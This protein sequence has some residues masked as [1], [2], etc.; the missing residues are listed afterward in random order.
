MRRRSTAVDATSRW[1]GTGVPP[2]SSRHT[3]LA[4]EKRERGETAMTM[5]RPAVGG[6]GHPGDD[7]PVKLTVR[8]G[9]DHPTGE[10]REPCLFI[11]ARE[12]R[13]LEHPQLGS[14]LHVLLDEKRRF[15]RVGLPVDLT[16]GVTRA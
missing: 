4:P 10:L 13:V 6:E 9:I 1:W 16:R 7:Q 8:L 15:A 2:A 5:L 12:L 3:V 14:A 11:E